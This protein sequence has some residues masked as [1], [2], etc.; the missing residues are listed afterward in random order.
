MTDRVQASESVENF[1][2]AIYSLQQDSDRVSTN[3]LSEYLNITAPSVTD[4]AKRLNDAG[5]VD[6]L[7]HH[8]VILTP[9]GEKIALHVVR[10]HRLIE[11]FLV[12]E[13]GYELPE[14][15][16]EADALEHA[17]SNRFIEAIAYKLGDPD[18][19]PHGD[20]IPTAEGVVPERELLPLSD[21]PVNGSFIV[22][23]L[24]ASNADMLLHIL[25]R[26]FKLNTHVAVISRDPFQGPI[27]V[28]VD[29]KEAIIGAQVAQFILVEPT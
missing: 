29:D 19:H 13:L 5:L 18:F 10:R 9:D 14:V 21:A 27:S 28:K 3:T 6:Y 16:Q 15:H 26:G 12:N 24:N 20:P 8:G 17:V 7:K 23:R 11:L 1:L 25:E 22:Q 4:M 2:K